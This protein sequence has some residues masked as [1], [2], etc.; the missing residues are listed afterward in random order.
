MVYVFHFKFHVLVVSFLMFRGLQNFG[1][2]YHD[3]VVF[4]TKHGDL[5][6]DNFDID[7]FQFQWYYTKI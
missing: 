7:D 6:T 5:T 1:F 4:R 3:L 2:A